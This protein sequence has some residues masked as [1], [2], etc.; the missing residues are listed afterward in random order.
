M[1]LGIH[2]IEWNLNLYLVKKKLKLKT[3]TAKQ[4]IFL[5]DSN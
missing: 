2:F 5:F 1:L 4:N 3:Y